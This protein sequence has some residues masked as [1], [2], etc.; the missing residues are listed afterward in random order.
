MTAADPAR[1]YA[2]VLAEHQLDERGRVWDRCGCGWYSSGHTAH[3]AAALLASPAHAAVIAAAKAEALR[4]AVDK[5]RN[6]AA[7]A[8]GG[9]LGWFTTGTTVAGLAAHW[10]DEAAAE[11]VTP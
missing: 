1:E 2:A 11:Q 8:W 4:E 7:P 9:D 3:L 5:L 6:E 10:L